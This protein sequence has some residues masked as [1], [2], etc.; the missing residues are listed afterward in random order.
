MTPKIRKPVK[1]CKLEVLELTAGGSKIWRIFSDLLERGS[2][3]LRVWRTL[4]WELRFCL[5]F[6][7][8]VDL[9]LGNRTNF[10]LQL[11]RTVL[12]VQ[13]IPLN[14][15]FDLVICVLALGNDA[16]DS[17]PGLI[18]LLLAFFIEQNSFFIFSRESRSFEAFFVGFVCFD[19]VVY[20]LD[21]TETF[22]ELVHLVRIMKMRE[23]LPL[24]MKS[25]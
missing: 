15:V 1:T 10:V 23:V 19:V 8:R 20:A 11:P 2:L 7:E 12:I 17:L 9:F 13:V 18:L 3:V 24:D 21:A 14:E 25:L 5:A 16:L 6:P 4:V 22:K